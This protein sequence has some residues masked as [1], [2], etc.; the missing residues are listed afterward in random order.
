VVRRD[1]NFR[2]DSARLK[3]LAVFEM[4]AGHPDLVTDYRSKLSSLLF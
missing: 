4:A 2:D 1:R 3:M